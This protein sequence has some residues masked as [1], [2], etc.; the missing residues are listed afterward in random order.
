MSTLKVDNIRHNSATSDAITMASDG[1]CTAKITSVG[2]GGLSHRN[3]LINGAMNIAQRYT[4]STSHPAYGADRWRFG[5]GNHS[6]GTVTA[7]QQSLSSSDTP[8]TLGFRKYIRLAL[9]QAGTAASNTYLNLRY[10]IEAQDIAQSGWNYN[11]SSSFITFQFWFR[12]STNQTFYAELKSDD[13]TAQSFVFSFTA[14]GNNTWTKITKTIPG[15]SNIQFDNDNGI[16]LAIEWNIFRGTAKTGSMTLDQWAAFDGSVRVPD[17]TTT[18]YTTNDATFEITGVQFEV[19]SQVTPFE[20]RS[21]GEE[22]SLCQRYYFNT[23]GYAYGGSS[24]HPNGAAPEDAYGSARFPTTMRASPTI[25]LRDANGNVDG[26]VTQ[27]GAAHDI[28]AT[29]SYI[30][31]TGFQKIIKSSGTFNN[32]TNWVIS[33][34]YTAN[35]EI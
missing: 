16:G 22:L 1:T 35:A 11:S 19:G 6:A 17:M 30:S 25:V 3:V 15:N 34:G 7:S 33:A 26:K 31:E 12:C 23:G 14:S 28:A 29:A 4:S 20:H 10:K 5:F 21:Y 24:W 13:G 2:G 9:G 32:T 8:Y 18:W 27:W